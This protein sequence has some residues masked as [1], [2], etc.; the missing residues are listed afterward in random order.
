MPFVETLA[1]RLI[2]KFD[3]CNV[4]KKITVSCNTLGKETVSRN[5]SEPDLSLSLIKQDP[6][7]LVEHDHAHLALTFTGP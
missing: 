7:R 4:S 5:I 6:V 2:H 1:I 3:L